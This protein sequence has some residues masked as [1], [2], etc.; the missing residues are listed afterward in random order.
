LL[1]YSVAFALW[2][3]LFRSFEFHGVLPEKATDLFF[4]WRNWVGK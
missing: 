4:G 2:S 3:F 1:H